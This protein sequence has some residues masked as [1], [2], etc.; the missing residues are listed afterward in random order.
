MSGQGSL[1]I[2]EFLI[3]LIISGVGLLTIGVMLLDY[4]RKK[5]GKK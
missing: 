5:N 1:I 2:A 4:K 3:P